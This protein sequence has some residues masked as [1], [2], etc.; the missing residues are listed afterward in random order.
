MGLGTVDDDITGRLAKSLFS[1]QPIHAT[2]PGTEFA[3]LENSVGLFNPLRQLT[4]ILQCV[5]GGPPRFFV[6]F[7]GVKRDGRAEKG[8]AKDE[9]TFKEISARY[10]HLGHPLRLRASALFS[11]IGK[12]H[13]FSA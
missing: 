13:F 2:L 7:I 10:R 6:F 12:N 5:I 4:L 11:S 8:A 9:R 1:L 3:R